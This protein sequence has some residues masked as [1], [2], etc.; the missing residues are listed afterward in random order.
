MNRGIFYFTAF[1]FLLIFSCPVYSAT[2]PFHKQVKEAVPF[3]RSLQQEVDI[4]AQ[5]LRREVLEE[6]G[7]FVKSELKIADGNIS[8]EELSVQTGAVSRMEVKHTLSTENNQQYVTVE[9][10]I[11]VDTDSVKNFLERIKQDVSLQEEMEKLRA[12]NSELEQ[13]LQSATK[14]Q[15][16]SGLA[17]EIA[18]QLALQKKY[19][20]EYQK[21]AIQAKEEFAKTQEDQ[22]KKEMAREA[23]IN[24][25]KQKIAQEKESV[26][27]ADL[28]NQLQIREM[29]SRAQK[30]LASFRGATYS[31]SIQEALQQAENVRMETAELLKKFDNLRLQQQQ[32][33]ENSYQEQIDLSTNVSPKDDWETEQSYQDRSNKNKEIVQRLIK[34]KK[35][36]LSKTEENLLKSEIDTLRPLISKLKE[37]Q[38]SQFHDAERTRAKFSHLGKINAEE[39]F[40]EITVEYEG[41]KYPLEYNFSDL[42]L[43]D[44]QLIYKTP[45]QFVVEPSFSV[46]A[47]KRNLPARILT[48]FTISHLGTNIEKNLP[49][50]EKSIEP[51]QEI[52][53]F[54][55]LRSKWNKVIDF[56]IYSE[57][58]VSY[59]I[60]GRSG[61]SSYF[62]PT[63]VTLDRLGTIHFIKRTDFSK[64]K[65]TLPGYNTVRWELDKDT[66]DTL[67]NPERLWKKAIQI[68][69]A[70]W[71]DRNF[72]KKTEGQIEALSPEIKK[73]IE[74]NNIV[75]VAEHEDDAIAW[76]REDGTV[77]VTGVGYSAKAKQQIEQWK[78][79][80]SI[81]SFAGVTAGLTEDGEVKWVYNN[82][83]RYPPT[84]YTTI[85]RIM[86]ND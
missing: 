82:E 71:I 66:K 67:E 58:V 62:D 53:Q 17:D 35:S 46:V 44:A 6:A 28:E 41:K 12:K 51:F 22:R 25:L 56:A 3:D 70:S 21:L 49:S 14:Q 7:S 40:F 47:D 29:E 5:R 30:N 60:E 75:D 77:Y 76:L 64:Y 13:R 33:I 61:A 1:A 43:S 4:L 45:Q 19:A 32:L 26:K 2:K 16:E 73:R 31:M 9:V 8:K 50:I 34:E 78:N 69:N 54:N 24:A 72:L 55:A 79:I 63:I 68:K 85:L 57:V 27:K 37:F 39:K 10:D 80:V 81:E 23:E 20:I 42:S 15:Y 18:K 38:H 86:S 48:A 36:A 52:N 84:P 65:P 11:W 74:R 83:N 59:G